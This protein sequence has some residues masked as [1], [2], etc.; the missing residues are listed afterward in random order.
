MKK[1][2]PEPWEWAIEDG[3][4]TVR[5]DGYGTITVVKGGAGLTCINAEMGDANAARIVACVN[6]CAGIS[7]EALESGVVAELVAVLEEILS[8]DPG[9]TGADKACTLITKIKGP[10]P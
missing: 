1:H 7:N 10:K 5:V 6:A 8:Y 4:R 2:T 3:F 9:A